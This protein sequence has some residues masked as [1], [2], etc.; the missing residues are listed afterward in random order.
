MTH[1]SK[2]RPLCLFVLLLS[3]P[4]FSQTGPPATD[5]YLADLTV[6]SGNISVQA[7]MNIT[8]RDGYDNQPMFLPVSPALLYTSIRADGQ[9]DTYLYNWDEATTTQIT[10]SA[11]SEYSPTVMPDGHHFSVVR[12]EADSS[13]RLWQFTLDGSHPFL[14]LPEIKPVGYH[15]WGD[16]NW[17]ALFIL[18]RPPSLQLANVS[19]GKSEKIAANIGRSLQK[20]P[21]QRAVS[22]VQKVSEK[23]SWLKRLDINTRKITPLIKTLP[24]SED[25]TWTPDGTL[26]MAKDATLFKWH[27][28]KDEY[29]V[30]VKR[31]EQPG[32]QRISR[33]AVSADGKKITLV[34]N[35]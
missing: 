31:F 34:S 16:E 20:I 19:S 5:I 21:N 14:L 24:G 18:G 30:E 11:E 8:D 10:I 35:R 4:S 1:F 22:F 23:E 6:N 33:L 2:R 26:L 9:A 28:Q 17:V 32:L 7:P 15:A 29:W 12:V 27:P 13:Q 3:A 25:H